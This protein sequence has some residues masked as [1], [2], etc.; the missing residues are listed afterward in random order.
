MPGHLRALCTTH[1][2]ELVLVFDDRIILR[3]IRPT[4]VRFTSASGKHAHPAQGRAQSMTRRRH[5]CRTRKDRPVSS[6]TATIS[7]VVRHGKG[8]GGRIS[9]LPTEHQTV[10]RSSRQSVPS[11][12]FRRFLPSARG[13]RAWIPPSFGLGP[14][15]PSREQRGHERLCLEVPIYSASVSGEVTRKVHK[16]KDEWTRTLPLF[17]PSTTAVA[18]PLERPSL[19]FA[20]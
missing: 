3:E 7:P 14:P 5:R 16:S 9:R 18:L 17:F 20:T 11:L 6:R 13:R 1:S 8:L 19:R 15:A 10:L 12:A 4:N 2:P